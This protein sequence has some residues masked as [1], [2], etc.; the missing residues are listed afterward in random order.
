M[1]R[2]HR[3]LAL[4][5]EFVLCVAMRTFDRSIFEEDDQ[6]AGAFQESKRYHMELA[7]VMEAIRPAADDFSLIPSH[8]GHDVLWIYCR[9]LR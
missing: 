2:S 8:P 6:P 3:P 7:A 5:F 4:N 9:R 1:S